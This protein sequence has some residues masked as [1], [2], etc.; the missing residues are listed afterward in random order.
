MEFRYENPSEKND[1]TFIDLNAGVWHIYF[2]RFYSKHEK[3]PF[4]RP[5]I[6]N[7]IF[8]RFQKL[9]PFPEYR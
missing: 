3:H 8:D 7:S 6:I 4:S 5:P 2:L 1:E 9:S